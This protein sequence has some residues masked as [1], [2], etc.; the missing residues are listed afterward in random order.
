MNAEHCHIEQASA[1]L[2]WEEN[3]WADKKNIN[4]CILVFSSSGE[5][6][7]NFHYALSGPEFSGIEECVVPSGHPLVAE[8]EM[9]R[10]GQSSAYGNAAAVMFKLC[11][12]TSA[13]PQPG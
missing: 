4:L 7:V 12:L 11:L 9:H 10:A 2:H 5:A 6:Q 13:R 1:D 3:V 8:W